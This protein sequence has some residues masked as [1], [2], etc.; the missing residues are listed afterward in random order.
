MTEVWEKWAKRTHLLL[1]PEKG[2]SLYAPTWHAV[3]VEPHTLKVA[4]LQVLCFLRAL[5]AV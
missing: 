1:K 2:Q 3:L 5:V 4:V